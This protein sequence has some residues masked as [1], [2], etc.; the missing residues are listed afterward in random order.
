MSHFGRGDRSRGGRRNVHFGRGDRSRAAPPM[1]HFGRRDRSRAGAQVLWAP[2]RE[3][4]R[5]TFLHTKG[6]RATSGASKEVGVTR[7]KWG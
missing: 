5:E 3:G 6:K 1:S 4:S 7:L 2:G